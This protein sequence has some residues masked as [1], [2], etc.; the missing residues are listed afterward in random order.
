M[1][2]FLIAG[3]VAY[4][5]ATYLWSQH[6]KAPDEPTPTISE[7]FEST[8]TPSPSPSISVSPSVTPAPA[9]T[10]SVNF[11]A[12]V[13]V[14]NGSS[15]K[16]LAAKNQKMLQTGGFTSVTAGNIASGKPK[17]NVVVYSSEALKSTAQEV[18]KQL[19]I[20]QISLDVPQT[21]VDVEVQLVT[22]P[23]A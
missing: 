22:D 6:A 15:V 2:V 4:L 23:A 8:V 1:I 3:A 5:I 21:S 10:V 9:E 11:D 17:S 20:D 12:K 16:G 19:G 18:A 14:L 13:A 7:T